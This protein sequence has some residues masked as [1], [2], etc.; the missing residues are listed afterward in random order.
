MRDNNLF[1]HRGEGLAENQQIVLNKESTVVVIDGNNEFVIHNVRK[2]EIKSSDGKNVKIT[3][4]PQVAFVSSN[5]K[6]AINEIKDKI[7]I[8]M[9][10][11]EE[12][13]DKYT[14][15]V[16][17]QEARGIINY[18]M[19]YTPDQYSIE[20]LLAQPLENLRKLKESMDDMANCY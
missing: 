8:E 5:T 20:A 18:I 3:L 7:Y 19:E 17:A 14:N 13:L 2:I 11:S 1:F 12:Q 9:L 4:G 15:V 16:N 10:N 6:I